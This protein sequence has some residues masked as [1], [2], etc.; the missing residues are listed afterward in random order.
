MWC[1]INESARIEGGRRMIPENDLSQAD[2]QLNILNDETTL[3]SF[4]EEQFLP[5]CHGPS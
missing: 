2:R 1:S 4:F 3:P 5:T